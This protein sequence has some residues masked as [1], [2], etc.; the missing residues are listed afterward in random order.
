[1]SNRSS[2]GRERLVPGL[3]RGHLV[4]RAL[5]PLST[6]IFSPASIGSVHSFISASRALLALIVAMPGRTGHVQEPCGLGGHGA[7]LDALLQA[8]GAQDELADVDRSKENRC[9]LTWADGG[10][11]LWC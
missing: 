6:E 5:N 4:G 7:Q 2:L 3:V 11:G 10:R 1:V 8:C 9:G